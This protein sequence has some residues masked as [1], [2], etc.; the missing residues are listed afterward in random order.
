MCDKNTGI[1][2]NCVSSQVGL[3]SLTVAS[4]K[5]LKGKASDRFVLPRKI[6]SSGA[7]LSGSFS[8]WFMK[9]SMA[10][11]GKSKLPALVWQ[12]DR[13]INNMKNRHKHQG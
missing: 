8:Q 11:V 10:Q 1:N 4:V 5:R 2:L 9:Y 12:D 3:F 13:G 7:T 6:T